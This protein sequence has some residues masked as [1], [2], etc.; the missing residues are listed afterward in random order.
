MRNLLRLELRELKE[1][2]EDPGE[3]LE[4][5]IQN[6]LGDLKETLDLAVSKLKKENINLSLGCLDK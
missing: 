1:I 6:S 3:D 5:R 4:K 2:E